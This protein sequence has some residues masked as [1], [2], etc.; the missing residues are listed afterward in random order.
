MLREDE[1][2]L[3]SKVVVWLT[4]ASGKPSHDDVVVRRSD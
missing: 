4:D 1:K 3:D 2:G